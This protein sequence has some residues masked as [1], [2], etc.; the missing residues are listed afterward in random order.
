VVCLPCPEPVPGDHRATAEQRCIAQERQPEA[1]A[2]QHST[3]HR[4]H[5]RADLGR[6][7]GFPVDV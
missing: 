7:P 3:E 6:D 1:D 5:R 2:R 4:A